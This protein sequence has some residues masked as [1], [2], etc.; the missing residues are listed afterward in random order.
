MVWMRSHVSVTDID[1]GETHRLPT[2]ARLEKAKRRDQRS[3]QDS[4]VNKELRR[5]IF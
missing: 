1:F 4:N 2:T 5:R 3:F